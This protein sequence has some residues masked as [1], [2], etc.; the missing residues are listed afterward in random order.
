[1]STDQ[2]PKNSVR[3][4][5][6]PISCRRRQGYWWFEAAGRQA[7]VSHSRGLAYLAVLLANPGREIPASDLASGLSQARR[8]TGVAAQPLLDDEAIRHYRRRLEQLERNAEPTGQARAERDWLRGQLRS[9]AGLAGR[10]RAFATEDERARIAVGK[11]IRRALG[12]I[13]DADPELGRALAEAVH[14]GQRCAYVPHGV[15]LPDGTRPEHRALALVEA[16]PEVRT[17]ARTELRTEA[18]TARHDALDLGMRTVHGPEAGRR[19]PAAP[20]RWRISVGGRIATVE[21]CRG[22]TYLAALVANPGHEMPPIELA[23][24]PGRRPPSTPGTAGDRTIQRHRDRIE[25]VQRR[26]E[27]YDRIGDREAAID[28]H[29]ER[30]ALLSRLRAATGMA[31]GAHPTPRD[32]E[33][34]RVAVGKA[35]RRALARIADADR[36]IGDLLA[37]GVHTGR[38]C[39][40]LPPEGRSRTRLDIVG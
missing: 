16:R 36:E 3:R 6:P 30:D 33:R 29:R 22:M 20:Q 32:E 2:L 15:G 38:R 34:A 8:A 17:E 11:A 13:A 40:Y 5:P 10:T 31:E 21:H 19:P 27:R 25:Q 35:I 7:I 39:I 12:R 1:V 26:I 18:R 24:E 9:A 14:T 4:G 23:A 37:V 28:A